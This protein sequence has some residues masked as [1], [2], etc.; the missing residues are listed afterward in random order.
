MRHD[1]TVDWTIIAFSSLMINPAQSTR[2]INKQLSD[3]WK[4]PTPEG[5]RNSGPFT[6][7]E[8]AAAFKR[9]G[10]EKLPGLDYIFAVCTPCW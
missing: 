1:L 8:L 5:N 10:S 7:E 4:V 9:L 2:L 6:L 3:L